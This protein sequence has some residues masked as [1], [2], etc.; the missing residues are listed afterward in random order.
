MTVISEGSSPSS[1]LKTSSQVSYAG[2][3]CIVVCD[4]ELSLRVLLAVTAA[5]EPAYLWPLPY[6]S[7]LVVG[8]TLL[9]CGL[10]SVLPYLESRHCYIL[11]IQPLHSWWR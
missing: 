10:Y 11:Q 4:E 5:G 9:L 1:P 6:P 2:H 7:L 8:Y 3:H